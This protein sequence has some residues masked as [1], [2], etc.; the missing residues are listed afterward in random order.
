MPNKKANITE[1]VLRD[2]QQ[3]LIATRMK[4][5]D[6]LPVLK[7][8]DKVGYSS[9]EV[10]GGATY[11]CCLRYLNENPWDRLKIFKKHIKKT[12]LQM[13]LRG[14]N[15]VGYK[16]YDDSVISLFIKNAVKEGINIFRIFDSLNDINNIKSS[17]EYVNRE[18]EN[19]QGTICYTTSPVHNEK[20]WITL[21]KNIEDIG[22]KSL[23][24]KDMAGLLRPNVG[25]DLIKKLKKNLK[26]PIY[27]HTHSTTGLADATNLKAYEAGVDNIDTSISSFSNL[28]AHTATESFISMIYKDSD[29][30]FDMKLLTKIAE[31]F[32]S[33]R[34]KYIQYEGSM[35]GVDINMLLYQV[36]G[37]MLSI[38]EKQLVDLKKQ[39]RLKDLID[40]IPRIRKDVGYVP[41]V[42]PSS[43]IVGA[44][45]LMN[46]LDNERYKTLN[47]EFI[48]LVNG[49]YGKIP[50]KVNKK[51]LNKIDK[52]ILDESTENFTIDSYKKD[53]SEFCK[54]NDLKDFSNK[55]TD[56]LNYILFP[57][58][59]KEY[60]LSLNKHTWN[61]VV[62]LQEGFG[63]FIE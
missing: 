58:E 63:L 38:L 2:G 49:K 54:S 62:G 8:L 56:L 23:A 46:V 52:N 18:G 41:L 19:S 57:K 37:G 7:L 28:Y 3:S 14:K 20:Y 33:I 59:S 44:Q 17:I 42:T 50:G 13:L 47:K 26:I 35:R 43:Q 1:V 22:A 61:D 31:Y 27:L 36:P 29:N 9:L 32:Q 16:E 11:D 24:I 60:Y 48:D 39:D 10:W 34:P 30:P 40:E 45:A 12:R 5:S 55:E 6:M 4:T 53:F 15:L 25:F 21:A 51:L